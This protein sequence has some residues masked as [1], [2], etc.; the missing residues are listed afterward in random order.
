[1]GADLYFTALVSEQL[2]VVSGGGGVES[3]VAVPR[4]T[5]HKGSLLQTM[6][7]IHRTSEFRPCV[8]CS[9]GSSTPVYSRNT[10]LLYLLFSNPSLNQ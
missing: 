8:K 4:L 5:G 9:P 6:S 10:L 7:A 1:M 2:T 3:I